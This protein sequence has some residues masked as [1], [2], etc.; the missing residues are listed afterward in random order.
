M[1]KGSTHSLKGTRLS[2]R[3][4]AAFALASALLLL[5]LAA[6][7]VNLNTVETPVVENFNTIGTTATAALPADFKA[8]KNVGRRVVGAYSTA[9]TATEQTAGGGSPT[10]SAGG[11][12]N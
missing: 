1:S 11:I 9:G 5:P 6:L 2:R 4:L 10:I 3:A 7:A 8:D 12:Y